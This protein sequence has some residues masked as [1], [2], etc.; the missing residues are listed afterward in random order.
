MSISQHGL[1]FCRAVLSAVFGESQPVVSPLLNGPTIIIV[2]QPT[3]GCGHFSLS[4]HML[5]QLQLFI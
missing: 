1:L 3:T 5:G 4:A 2:R